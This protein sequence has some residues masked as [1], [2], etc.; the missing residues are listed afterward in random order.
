MLGDRLRFLRNRQKWTQEDLSKKLNVAVSTVSGYEGGSR[1]PDIETLIRLA[2]L[3]EVSI[4]YLVGRDAENSLPL[5]ELGDADI[6]KQVRLLLDS[7]PLSEEDTKYLLAIIREKRNIN[8][9]LNAN[10]QLYEK[11]GNAVE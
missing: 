6:L 1:R 5:I 3:F 10:E 2:E 11:P 7:Q 9:F 8:R 4:D